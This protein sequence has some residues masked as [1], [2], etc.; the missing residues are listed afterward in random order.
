MKDG[1]GKGGGNS[2]LFNFFN[3]TLIYNIYFENI[4]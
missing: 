3:N 2:S 4:Y 1:K